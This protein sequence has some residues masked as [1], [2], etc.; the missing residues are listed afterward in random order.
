MIYVT[1]KTAQTQKRPLRLFRQRASQVLKLVRS[2]YKSLFPEDRTPLA[3]GV[4]QHIRRLS[5]LLTEWRFVVIGPEATNLPCRQYAVNIKEHIEDSIV[6][7]GLIRRSEA[8][9]MPTFRILICVG[10]PRAHRRANH[11]ASRTS[12]AGAGILRT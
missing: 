10:V 4:Q 8:T 1:P 9:E 2:S 7:G 11:R 3:D 5:L 6:V 12:F